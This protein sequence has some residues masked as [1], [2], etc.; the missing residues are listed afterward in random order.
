MSALAAVGPAA[1]GARRAIRIA[2]ADDL[3]AA[4]ALRGGSVG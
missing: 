1:D 2:I 4:E 3:R